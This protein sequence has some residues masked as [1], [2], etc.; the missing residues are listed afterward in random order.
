[1]ESNIDKTKT[2]DFQSV[3]KKSVGEKKIGYLYTEASY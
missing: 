1:M 2:L 3:G